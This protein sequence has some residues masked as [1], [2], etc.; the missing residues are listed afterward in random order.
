MFQEIRQILVAVILFIKYNCTFK[1]VHDWKEG[2]N[3]IKYTE[4]VMLCLL[5]VNV[6]RRC[7]VPKNS[8]ALINKFIVFSHFQRLSPPFSVDY[9]LDA[10]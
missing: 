10:E 3:D 5:T 6:I 8:A 4:K 2:K 7:I 1:S 9:S